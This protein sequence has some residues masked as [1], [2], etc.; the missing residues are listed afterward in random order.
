MRP[1]GVTS[2]CGKCGREVAAKKQTVQLPAPQP[3][4]RDLGIAPVPSRGPRPL[5]SL[6]VQPAPVER[7]EKKKRR[8]APVQAEQLPLTW[9]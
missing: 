4:T 3:R 8:G 1:V 7:P 2:L 6:K 9:A 5:I